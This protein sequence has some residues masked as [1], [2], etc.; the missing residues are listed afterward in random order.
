MVPFPVSEG[1]VPSMQSAEIDV[2]G[3]R[4]FGI[5]SLSW[6]EACE[7]EVEYGNG[8]EPIGVT[9]GQYAANVE[10]E[11]LYTEYV[12][13][14]GKVGGR[15]EGFNVGF[16]VTDP[17]A[18]LISMVIPACRLASNAGSFT[19]KAGLTVKYK[20]Q[21]LKMIEINGL[22]IV[23]RAMSS[24]VGMSVGAVASTGGLLVSAGA[25]VAIG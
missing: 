15:Q 21:V 5:K 17:I 25:A 13:L 4:V 24:G 14:R 2:K 18:G 3:S 19:G 16:Q 7:G 10:I 8:V 11:Q 20:C 9:I 22:T 1:F 23:Q 12:V 6:D